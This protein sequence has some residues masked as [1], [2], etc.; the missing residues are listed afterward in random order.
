MTRIAE[1]ASI[2]YAAHCKA[3]GGMDITGHH[4]TPWKD[5]PGKQANA[6]MQAV[7]AIDEQLE[8]EARPAPASE[9]D[10]TGT[11]VDVTNG[12][13]TSENSPST[14]GGKQEEPDAGE[15]AE[16]KG[17]KKSRARA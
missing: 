7:K 3:M 10:P 15:K 5:L 1:L 14:E 9:K 16:P 8:D 2:A 4:C 13:V 11:F 6:W 12:D 17:G